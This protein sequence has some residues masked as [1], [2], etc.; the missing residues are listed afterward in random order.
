MKT[1][2]FKA[3]IVAAALGVTAS[4]CSLVKDL[5]YEVTP[6][7][8][9]MHGDSVEVTITAIVPEKGLNKK[10]VADVS[11]VLE[12]EG[13][14]KE[15]KTMTIQGEK[16]A[17]NG[18]VVPKAGKK[19]TYTDKIP[20]TKDMESCVLKM[21]V[22]AKKGNKTVEEVSDELCKG[23]IVTPE[24]VLSDDRV[25][26][27][28]D[29]F[30]RIT[31]H[32]VD[33]QI[34]YLVNNSS[35]RGSE[36]KDQ[37]MKDMKAFIDA[38]VENAKITYKTLAVEAYASPEGELSKNENLAN[39]RAASAA[40]STR[41]LFR[42]KAAPKAE[43]LQDALAGKGEDWNGF[44]AA[45]EASDIGDKDLIIRVLQQYKGE[46]RET[47]IKNMAQTYLEL[48]KDILPQLRRSQIKLNYELM[49]KSDAE[50]TA[51]AKS[52]PDSLNVEELLF[53]AT[54]TE[55]VNEQLRIYREACR[56]YPNDWRGF[57]NV[58]YCL[59]MQN[60]LSDAATEFEKAAN[61]SQD[62]VIMNNLGVVARLQGDREKAK[63]YYAKAS[64]AGS[65]VNY[66]K[67]IVAIMDGDYESALSNFGSEST[68]NVA[69][70]K[71]LNG[72]NDGALRALENSPEKDTAEGYYL[73]AILGARMG[74]TDL[75]VNNLK[76][77]I[78]KNPSLKEKA[79]TDLE[80]YK[81]W[82]DA[83]F[84]GAVN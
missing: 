48:K 49:G 15:M 60:K 21:K 81:Y 11:A 5:S 36:M 26:I 61:L 12:W 67:G 10:A 45:V 25:L 16:A 30:Q 41:K 58:G 18:T 65:D 50:L 47:E 39:E 9:E 84:T 3:L 54:L 1:R 69:L 42:K 53:S 7:P 33:G 46:D 17:G 63:E 2:N 37:D 6:C 13:G 72:D 27:G 14:S 22:V 34:N 40:E 66:N 19:L 44:K 52:N 35:V 82:E 80:F 55:D 71:M 32:S 70:A 83:A 79:K 43:G 56:I 20:Y 77:A 28:K 75:M 59:M 68:F 8:L 62:A 38:S 73:K 23:T 51:L 64:G 57:N 4:S 74:N 31:M 24:M 78:A 76:S 29:N